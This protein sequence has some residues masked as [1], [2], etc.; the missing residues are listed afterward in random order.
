MVELLKAA[1]ESQTSGVFNGDVSAGEFSFSAK[2]LTLAGSY[3]ISEHI[4]D[5]TIT[6][7]PWLLSCKRIES[8]IRKYL[9]DEG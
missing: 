6:Q 4:I 8:E 1:I 5:V 7:K 9:E 2:G 3:T